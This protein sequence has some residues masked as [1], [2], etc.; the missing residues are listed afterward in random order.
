MV[1]GL[2]QTFRQYWL[3]I[4]SYFQC[5]ITQG[6]IEAINGII[7][8]AKRR[9]RQHDPARDADRARLPHVQPVRKHERPAIGLAG[10]Y[11]SFPDQPGQNVRF[12]VDAFL[13]D[14]VIAF[15]QVQA[16][17]AARPF[18]AIGR[19]RRLRIDVM[20]AAAAVL[21]DATLATSNK[22]NF[23]ML[24]PHGLKFVD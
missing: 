20:I 19:L 15:E 17:E 10:A 6:A 23:K 9:A 12:R 18:N 4:V 24:V 7:Q 14:G 11:S 22:D 21:A 16:I 13:S 1:R 8:L 2:A 5:R 3:G